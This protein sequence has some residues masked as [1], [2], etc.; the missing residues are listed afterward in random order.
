[1]KITKI[2]PLILEVNHR[3]DWVFVLIHTDAGITGLGEASHSS[4]DALLVAMV[5]QF[6]V[7]LAGEDPREISSIWARIAKQQVG[8]VGN[9]A[10]SAIEQA[11]WDILGQHLGVPIHTLFGGAVH[12]RLRLYANINR[13]MKDRSPASFATAAKQAVDEGF[14]AIKLAPFDELVSPHRI[15]TGPN[16]AS[17][18]G[19]ERVKAVRA[20]IGDQVELAVDCHSRMETSEAIRV[21]HELAACNLFWYEEPVPEAFPDELAKVAAAVPMPVAAAESVYCMEGFR[22]FL[23]ERVVDVIMPDVKHNGGLMETKRIAGAARMHNVLVA[24]HQPAGPVA[25]AATAQVV[26]TDANFYVLEHAW[27]EVSWRA[28]LLQP[29]ERIEDGHLILAAESGI[30]HR[31]NPEIVAQYRKSIASVRDSSKALST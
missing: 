29:A 3:G 10:V 27:G 19:I 8:R 12:K 30:G 7:Q 2:E 16:A 14:T 11:L 20:A 23:T 13:H 18:P 6:S 17:R 31:L 22:P 28:N 24:P 4:N 21:G 9:T 15:R 1:M 5:E 26:S 25:T